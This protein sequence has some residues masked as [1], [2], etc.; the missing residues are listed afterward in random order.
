MKIKKAFN[1][2]IIIALLLSGG[3]CFSGEDIKEPRLTEE[4]IQKHI[5]EVS[6]HYSTQVITQGE[7]ELFSKEENGFIAIGKIGIGEVIDLAA[8]EISGDTEYF[9]S[10]SLNSYINFKSVMPDSST[11]KFNDRHLNYIPFNESI[12][13]NGKIR[14]YNDMHDLVYEL[15]SQS[16][17]P[18]LI[19]EEEA[20][21]VDYDGRLL[22]VLKKDEPSIEKMTNSTKKKAK[23]IRVLCYHKLYKPKNKMCHKITCHDVA[24]IAK[25]FKY[26][27][28]N[29]YFTMSMQEIL[30]FID[31]KINVP[32]KSTCI[33]FDDGGR[34]TRFL[35]EL[36]EKYDLHATLFLIGKM[37]GDDM[38]S[39]NLE[40][41]AHTYNFHTRNHCSKTSFGSAHMCK[42]Q[43]AFLADLIKSKELT[44]AIAFAY[45]YY[46]YDKQTIKVVKEAGFLLAFED[47]HGFVRKGVN[48]FT[49]SR[50]TFI[51][52]SSLQ[53]LKNVLHP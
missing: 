29:K 6:E 21:G 27:S 26:L 11:P 51:R 23:G 37:Y 32:Y 15:P 30:W 19:K 41:Q 38:I 49:I 22:W 44:N 47:N 7:S 42:S 9:F 3:G 12:K 2:L 52:S 1:V 14:L 34:N 40:L 46:E 10:D 4:D 50:F 24:Q 45:P 16:T 33:T 36:L 13:A 17:F 53:D 39:D 5:S 35:V 48:K 25:H 31:G 43:K 8:T 18:I 20:Y 28:K